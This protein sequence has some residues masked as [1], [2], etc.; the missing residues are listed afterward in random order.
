[1]RLPLILMWTGEFTAKNMSDAFFSFI[2]W[3]RRSMAIFISSICRRYAEMPRAGRRAGPRA[4]RTSNP[5]QQF[6]DAGLRAGLRVDAL[7]DH[8]AVQRVLAVVR[9]QVARHD[10]RAGRHAAIGHFAGGA[11]VDLGRLAD[12]DAHRDHRVLFDDD[13]FDDFRARADEAV[14]FDDGR[15]GLHRFEHAA[16]A[17]A[18]GQVDVL[19][20]LR[21]G[22]DGGPGVDHRA[23]IDVGADVDVGRHQH[24]VLGDEGAAAC[25]GR[26]HH[27]EAALGE[28]FRRVVGELGRH[29]VVELHGAVGRHDDVVLK[30]E[31][32]QHGFLDPLVDDPR[33]AGFVGH[34]DG[35]GVEARDDVRDGVAQFGAAVAWVD[36][37]AVVPGLVDDV[38]ELLGHDVL[39]LVVQLMRQVFAELDDAM[40]RFQTFFGLGHQ[41]HADAVAPRVDAVRVARQVAARQDGDIIFGVQALREF[42]VGQAG[43]ADVGP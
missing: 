41:C 35:A 12:V 33:A 2:S 19:A 1:M 34:A 36:L 24:D 23:F 4:A 43:L 13:A 21:A 8:R 10:H 22:A 11:V 29:F 9:R 37:G 26:R 18:A 42:G 14:V 30:P 28:I 27:A 20:D 38:L 7:D 6:V 40:R 39:N 17:D 15:I 31:R 5:A 25:D 3:N 16:D 32:Q